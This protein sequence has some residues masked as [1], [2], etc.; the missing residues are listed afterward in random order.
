LREEA[1]LPSEVIGP[2]D[3]APLARAACFWLSVRI[4]LHIA[5]DVA[6]VLRIRQGFVDSMGNR[7]ARKM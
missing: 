1:S 7:G 5:W 4:R 2:R 3:F 6:G